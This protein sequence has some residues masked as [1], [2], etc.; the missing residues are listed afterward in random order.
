M[1]MDLELTKRLKEQNQIRRE[2]IWRYADRRPK[3]PSLVDMIKVLEKRVS[4]LE[5]K[6][7]K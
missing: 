4:E 3:S 1:D 2:V 7:L 5:K 6:L